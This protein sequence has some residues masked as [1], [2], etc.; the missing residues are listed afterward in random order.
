M[1]V[2]YCI[3]KG[4]ELLNDAFFKVLW[5][6]IFLEVTKKN[7]KGKFSLFWFGEAAGVSH[8]SGTNVEGSL[9][10]DVNR[11]ASLIFIDSPTGV[12]RTL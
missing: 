11:L 7:E 1:S 6:T 8:N 2:V 9:E 3:K 4:I 10:N 5:Q 12:S